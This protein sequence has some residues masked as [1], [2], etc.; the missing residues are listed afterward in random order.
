MGQSQL[1]LI[2]AGVLI[3]I[4][5]FATAAG[6]L[7]S[8]DQEAAKKAMINDMNSIAGNA[9]RYYVRPASMVGGNNQFTGYVVPVR[10]RKNSNGVYSATVINP[11]VL[12]ITG[13]WS[14]DTTAGIIVRIDNLG[15][16]SGWT[17]F[18]DFE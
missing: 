11:K 18:G 17:F 16:A 2:T 13:K 14:R 12:Q 15:K 8:E 6:L 5:A 3:A 9:R 4:L 1:L 10:F 7:L